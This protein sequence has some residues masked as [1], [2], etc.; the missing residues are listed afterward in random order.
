MKTL[1]NIM[2]L[3]TAV[4][5]MAGCSRSPVK[6][7]PTPV[8][9]ADSYASQPSMPLQQDTVARPVIDGQAVARPGDCL[10]TIAKRVYG[11]P[12]LWPVLCWRN[13]LNI[14]DVI[15]A[16]DILIYPIKPSEATAAQARSLA[17]GYADSPKPRKHKRNR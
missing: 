9:V 14:C 1:V 15:G 6:P 2:V 12:W 4:A 17:Y 13:N 5:C 11:E 7:V 3:A 8:V 16:G 10:W